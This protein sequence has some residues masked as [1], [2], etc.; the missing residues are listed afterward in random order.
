MAERTTPGTRVAMTIG[1]SDSSGAVGIQADLKTFAV[2]DVYGASVLTAVTAQNT[3]AVKATRFMDED[4]VEQQIDAIASDIGVH[5]TKVGITGQPA[6]V[7][8]V[9]RSLQRHSLFP[10][11]VDPAMTTKTGGNSDDDATITALCRHLLPFAA[12][13]T[14]NRVEATRM[15]G[16][17]DPIEDLY[18]A[19][20]AAVELCRRFKVPACV[21]TGIHRP[22]DEEGDAVDLYFDGREDH[23]L[24]SDWRPTSNTQGAGDTFSAAIT[25]SLAL[26]E[27]LD[28]AVQTAKRVVSESIRQATDLGQGDS[29]VNP[30]AYAH[31]S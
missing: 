23:E 11:V 21:I 24:V 16:R 4:L 9:A 14:P 10:L 26:G 19:K 27:S 15:L 25:A 2:M 13:T 28:D 3:R 30:L 12:I 17:S 8:S 1:G 29:P 31:V 18:G 5:A 7:Q 20:D 22:S 6:L